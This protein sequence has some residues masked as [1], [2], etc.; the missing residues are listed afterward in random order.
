MAHRNTDTYVYVCI[1][2]KQYIEDDIRRNTLLFCRVYK[3]NTPSANSAYSGGKSMYHALL[4]SN[5]YF[6]R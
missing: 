1:N 2:W 3:N 4:P 5:V 6:L